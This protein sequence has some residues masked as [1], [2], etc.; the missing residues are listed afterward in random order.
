MAGRTLEI[1]VPHD[2]GRAEARRRVA[3]GLQ[4]VQARYGQSVGTIEQR[5]TGDRLD[6]TVTALGQRIS[7]DLDIQDKAVHIRVL[8]PWLL[9]RIAEKLR[10][11]IENEARRVL[12]LPGPASPP[13]AGSDSRRS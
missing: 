9:A 8:L 6:F 4:N 3:D 12:K 13:G 1:S 5:W 11:Q 7:G 10:P 2:L